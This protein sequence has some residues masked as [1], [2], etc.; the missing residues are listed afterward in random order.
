MTDTDIRLADG[1]RV[2]AAAVAALDELE[3]IWPGATLPQAR[4]AIAAA[5]LEA[6]DVDRPYLLSCSHG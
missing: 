1:R 6:M 2:P 5:V 3:K 4:A